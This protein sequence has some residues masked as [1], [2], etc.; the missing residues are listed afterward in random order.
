MYTNAAKTVI[1]FLLTAVVFAGCDDI[2]DTEPGTSVTQEQTLTSPDGV[3]ALRATMYSSLRGSFSFTTQYFVGPAAFADLTRNSVGSSRYQESHAEAQDGDGQT[4]HITAWSPGYG[5]INEANLLIHGVEEGV[6]DEA[7]RQQYRGEALAMRAFAMHHM[8]R[9]LGY[10]PHMIDESSAPNWDLGIILRTEPT[11]NLEDADERPRANVHEVYDQIHDDL[12]DAEDLLEE[13][14]SGARNYMN[15]DFVKGLRARVHLYEGEWQAAYEAA[16]DAIASFE[17]SLADDQESVATMFGH[18]EFVGEGS[19]SEALFFLDPDP[20]TEQLASSASDSPA[21]YTG[22]QWVA[23]VPTDRWLNLY[24]EDDYRF[25]NIADNEGWFEPCQSRTLGDVTPE[26]CEVVNDLGWMAIKWSGEKGQLSDNVPYLRLS[27][28]Y[29]IQAEAVEHGASGNGLEALNTLRGARGLDD[30]DDYDLDEI[31]DE[32]VRELGLEGHRFWD[33]KRLG[34]DITHVDW[35]QFE[36]GDPKFTWE[37]SFRYIG[38][39]PLDELSVNN[40]LC[41]NPGYAGFGNNP[42][43]CP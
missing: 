10:E 20:A 38:M 11:Q 23:Q 28:L 42:D 19:H 15:A 34:R 41:Q 3:E 8:V 1:V 36:D 26:D 25:G 39:I 17:N 5:L 21:G 32:R 16:D 40:E 4:D 12:N 31:L 13:Y 14:G 33:K 30:L 2:F 43:L 22:N 37:D 35:Q 27:E 18:P 29:L 6:L 24:D 7:T 9:G